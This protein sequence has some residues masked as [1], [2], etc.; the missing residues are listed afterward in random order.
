MDFRSSLMS[1][2]KQKYVSYKPR[3]CCTCFFGELSHVMQESDKRVVLAAD[4]SSAT[5][6]RSGLCYVTAS[7]FGED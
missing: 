1:A 6:D 7:A 2:C 5:A 4:R 3:K